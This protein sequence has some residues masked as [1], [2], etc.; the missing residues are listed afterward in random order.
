MEQIFGSIFDFI[1]SL[2]LQPVTFIS[3]FIAYYSYKR[4]TRKK[5]VLYTKVNVKVFQNCN[6]KISDFVSQYKN[7]SV[8]SITVTRYLVWNNSSQA[9]RKNDIAPRDPLQFS[10]NSSYEILYP[11]IIYP[12]DSLNGFMLSELKKPN[13]FT[14]LSFDFINENEGAIIQIIHTGET[15]N[16]SF[17]GTIIDFKKP[18]FIEQYDKFDQIFAPILANVMPIVFFLFLF[19]GEFLHL[20]ETSSISAWILILIM[21]VSSVNVLVTYTRR[22]IPRK[23]RST[24]N[25]NCK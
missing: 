8:N 2:K 18:V 3:L 24:L 9:I 15:K 23:F 11:E 13:N 14:K 20:I 16:I 22:L 5:E 17:S 12:K 21:A 25:E 1:K 4:R 6:K 7:K 19:S 10:V